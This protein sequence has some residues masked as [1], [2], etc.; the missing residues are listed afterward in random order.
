[1]FKTYSTCNIINE[2]QARIPKALFSIQLFIDENHLFFLSEKLITSLN[3]NIEFEIVIVAPNQKKSL[4]LINLLKRLI[5]GGAEIYWNIDENSFENESYFAIFD[6]SYLI[7]GEKDD[8]NR[9]DEANYIEGKNTFFKSIILDSK[10]INLQTGDIKIDFKSDHYIVRKKETV[11]I[12]WKVNNAHHVSI[13][14]DIGQVNLEGSRNVVLYNDQTYRLVAKNK[15][16]V[17]EKN[18]FIKIKESPDMEFDVSVFDKTL[19]DFITLTPSGEKSFHYG[20]YLGQLVRLKWDFGFSGKL[21]EKS[22][23][24]LPLIGSYEFEVNEIT[25]FTFILNLIDGS[26]SKNLIFH[27]FKEEEISNFP[28]KRENLE[29]TPKAYNPSSN[30]FKV[31]IRKLKDI[32]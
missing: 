18:I 19:K 20:V 14:P 8:L 7:E 5:D 26:I 10:K 28:K 2:I 1:M 17:V 30:R 23:G 3:K 6:K 13:H 24:K 29:S 11:N 31:L 32:F 16:L 22:I 9:I 12:S 25:H 21:I 27:T 15:E 4:K